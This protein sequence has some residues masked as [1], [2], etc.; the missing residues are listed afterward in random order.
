M[1]GLAL[2][3]LAEMVVPVLTV[4]LQAFQLDT[5]AVALE[6]LRLALEL[7]RKEGAG[8]TEELRL[9]L[10]QILVVVAMEMQPLQP[11]TAAPAS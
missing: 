2:L 5:L 11:V 4:P 3:A 1:V 10:S 9:L 7:L 6:T 8:E